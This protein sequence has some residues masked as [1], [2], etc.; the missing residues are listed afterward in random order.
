MKR[1][2]IKSSFLGSFWFIGLITIALGGWLIF[3]SIPNLAWKRVELKEMNCE[4]EYPTSWMREYK[5]NQL[6]DFN[7]PSIETQLSPE[8]QNFIIGDYSLYSEDGSTTIRISNFPPDDPKKTSDMMKTIYQEAYQDYKVIQESALVVDGRA[9]FQRRDQYYREIS[10]KLEYT[11]TVVT[12]ISDSKNLY[13]VV[14]IEYSQDKFQA[15]LIVYEQI[16]DSFHV[17]SQ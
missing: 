3:S 13:N 4:I 14:L 5:I 1:K 12:Y 9:A 7:Y 6:G 15:S 11:A 10:G 17:L 2:K 8:M 16:L